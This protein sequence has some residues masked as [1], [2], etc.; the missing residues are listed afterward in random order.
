[1]KKQEKEIKMNPFIAGFSLMVVGAVLFG[2][3]N[4]YLRYTERK[5]L[6][7]TLLGAGLL[8]VVAGA[9]FALFWALTEFLLY[10]QT[11]QGL[12]QM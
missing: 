1:M 8:A 11:T 2:I 4:Y 6:A 9:A 10:L 3:G 12:P 5:I 7:P